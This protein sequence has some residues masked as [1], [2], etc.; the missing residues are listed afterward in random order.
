M[1]F[2]R[3]GAQKIGSITKG[4]KRV[5]KNL[6]EG[7]GGNKA[8]VCLLKWPFNIHPITLRMFL[9]LTLNK[10][11]ELTC[12]TIDWF[13]FFF[14]IE[15]LPTFMIHFSF[16]YVFIF[17][18]LYRESTKMEKNSESSATGTPIPKGGGAWRKNSWVSWKWF[19]SVHYLNN[20]VYL[21]LSAEGTDF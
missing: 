18:W 12:I 15:V 14:P 17:T 16:V 3:S 13:R 2:S 10:L 7:G 11:F 5:Q 8:I 21:S 19:F 6:V 1:T 20:T 4:R 9:S